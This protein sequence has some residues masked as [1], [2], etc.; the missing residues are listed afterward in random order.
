M[1]KACCLPLCALLVLTDGWSAY[2]GSIR[3]AFREKVKR[4]GKRGRCQLQG[5]PEIVIGTVIKKTAKKHVVEV[6]RRMAQGTIERAEELLALSAGGIKLNTADHSNAS[7]G[8][9][10]NAWQASLV[11][12]A[13]LPTASRLSKRVC[14]WS[15]A[16]TIG[17]GPIMN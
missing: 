15:A 3:R 1:V 9:C 12:L 14:G 11:A 8:R 17:A 5:W 6:I 13:M 10:A 7:M 2:P 16:P 4:A